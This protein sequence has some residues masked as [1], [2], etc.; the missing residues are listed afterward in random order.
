MDKEKQINEMKDFAIML[1]IV[2]FDRINQLESKLKVAEKENDNGNQSCE[3]N[4][5][6]RKLKEA[7]RSRINKIRGQELFAAEMGFTPD[8]SPY[9]IAKEYKKRADEARKETAKEILQK[10]ISICEKE[11]DF[12]CGEKV[13]TQPGPTWFGISNGL[14]FVINELHELA[15]Q[16]GVEVEE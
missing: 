11:K 12:Q 5:L 3:I 7:E 6:K 14:S 4:Q 15:K 2:L 1:G 10:A 8:C 16:Y 13:N 9:Y